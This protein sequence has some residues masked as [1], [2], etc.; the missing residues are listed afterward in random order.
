[1]WRDGF[2]RNPDAGIVTAGINYSHY[3]IGFSYDITF[4]QLKTAVD[5]KGAFEIALIYKAKN[6]RLSK[7]AI[8]CERY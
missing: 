5:S 2:K 1:M 8:P 7:K 4:S 3:T 6:T